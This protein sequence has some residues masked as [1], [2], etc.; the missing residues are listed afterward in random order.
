VARPDLA[1]VSVADLFAELVD[2]LE[3][4][5]AERTAAIVLE[6]LSP[7]DSRSEDGSAPALLDR[8]GLGRALGASLSTVDRLVRDGCPF[9]VAGAS[10]RF[11]L[12]R[13][14]AWLEARNAKPQLRAIEGGR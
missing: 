9:I 10:K 2:Q 13:V 6:R 4:R 7:N 1:G 8:A 5:C 3:R 12:D 11:Q 14:L